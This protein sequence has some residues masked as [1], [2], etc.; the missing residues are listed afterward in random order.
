MDTSSSLFRKVLSFFYLNIKHILTPLKI[1][2]VFFS[3]TCEV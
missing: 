1:W 3:L 2:V